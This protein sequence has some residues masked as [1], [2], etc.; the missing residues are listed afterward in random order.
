MREAVEQ[1]GW[2]DE[3]RRLSLE[4]AREFSWDRTARL[5]HDVYLEA[6]R[7]FGN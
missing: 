3:R 1:T 2:A 7:R 4:R 5:T 6:R